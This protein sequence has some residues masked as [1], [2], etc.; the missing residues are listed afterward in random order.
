MGKSSINGP[1]VIYHLVMTNIAMENP[2]NRW[3]YV[4]GKILYF[5]G[6]SIPWRTV[7]HNQRVRHRKIPP[8]VTSSHRRGTSLATCRP[9]AHGK[10]IHKDLARLQGRIGA[11]RGFL[12]AETDV[13]EILT[14]QKKRELGWE[15]SRSP[16]KTGGFKTMEH[17][18]CTPA[19]DGTLEFN[20]FKLQMQKNEE[21]T[22]SDGTCGSV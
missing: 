19:N 4:A 17:E 3:R 8:S 5:Y 12:R 10:A 18:E 14:C 11:V 1:S 20:Q 16:C 2:Q 7:S 9:H 22:I 15:S 13:H 21:F 6:P